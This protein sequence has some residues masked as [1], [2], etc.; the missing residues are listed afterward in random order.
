MRGV[1]HV[2]G[3]DRGAAL[4]YVDWILPQGLTEDSGCT[5]VC[6]GAGSMSEHFQNRI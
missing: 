2:G 6:P 4:S 1:K 3:D 5:V